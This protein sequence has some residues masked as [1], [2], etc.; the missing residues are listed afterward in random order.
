M[1]EFFHRLRE[2]K[3]VQWGLAY[4]AGAWLILEVSDVVGDV[5]N[6]PVFLLRALVVVLALGFLAALVVAWFHGE[7]GQ[8]HMSGLEILLLSTILLTAGV[9]VAIATAVGI[10]WSKSKEPE[11]D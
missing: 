7:K 3:I 6:W 10:G 1:Q 11:E 4:L 8:Q 9:T 2:R 5:F